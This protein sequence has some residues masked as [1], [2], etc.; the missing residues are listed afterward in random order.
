[1]STKLTR[2]QYEAKKE[3]YDVRL[4]QLT[5]EYLLAP[6]VDEAK[7]IEDKFKEHVALLATVRTSEV[8]EK[9]FTAASMCGVEDGNPYYVNYRV[10]NLIDLVKNNIGLRKA[11]RYRKNTARNMAKMEREEAA[12]APVDTEIGY[13]IEGLSATTGK[14]A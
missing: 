6:V 10:S 13:K 1:M 9:I 11:M 7:G 2:R 5:R 8:Y 12:N 4:V 14:M 3:F